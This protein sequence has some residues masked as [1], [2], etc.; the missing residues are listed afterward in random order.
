MG[1]FG[2][3]LREAERRLPGSFGKNGLCF[4]AR[5]MPGPQ[6]KNPPRQFQAGI[7]GS[8]NVAGVSI[9]S[10]G[11][12]TSNG[13]ARR[14][15]GAGSERSDLSREFRGIIGIKTAG[16]SGQAKHQICHPSF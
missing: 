8:G 15:F 4:P 6:K 13:L 9:A 5:E 14:F 7:D 10:V 2:I 16:D 3:D 1:Q 11:N 12:D